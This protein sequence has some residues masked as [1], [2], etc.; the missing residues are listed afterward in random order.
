MRNQYRRIL[1]TEAVERAQLENYRRVGM[2]RDDGDRLIAMGLAERTFIAERDSFYLASANENG[3]PYVQHR[4]G[5]KGFLKVLDE[6]RLAFADL[7]GN[8]QMISVGNVS[9]NDRVSLFLMDYRARERLK[10]IGRAKVISPQDDPELASLL[11]LEPAGHGRIFV[12]EVV[13]F[14]WNCPKFITQRFTR[15]EVEEAM[16]PLRQRIEELEARL[17]ELKSG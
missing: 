14:D 5:A 11:G 3:W 15:V 16:R 7:E 8:R 13:G 2:V 10:I 12:I 9:A 17:G 1:Q 4:G 6:R